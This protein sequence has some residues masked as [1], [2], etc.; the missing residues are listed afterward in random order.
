M[1]N[2]NEEMAMKNA[3]PRIV[4]SP[5]NLP[6]FSVKT[7]AAAHAQG[8]AVAKSGVEPNMIFWPEEKCKETLFL[9]GS[10]E[11]M[12]AI[13]EIGMHGSVLAV[14]NGLEERINLDDVIESILN[15]EAKEV[16]I[17]APGKSMKEDPINRDF[18]DRIHKNISGKL[19]TGMIRMK[20]GKENSMVAEMKYRKDG[21]TVENI[22]K[23]KHAR[24]IRFITIANRVRNVMYFGGIFGMVLQIILDA[25]DSKI[26]PEG[27]Y[28][29]I[30]F[31]WMSSSIIGLI[32]PYILS[33]K[34]PWAFSGPL[35][36]M[37]YKKLAE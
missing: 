17:C 1:N 27:I 5:E 23:E 32:A 29:P 4:V 19:K 11:E 14:T 31:I 3:S 37:I 36:Y 8:I 25:V 12:L 20:N 2:E 30:F 33:I 10:G 28:W 22:E 6:Y 26:I 13:K 15:T 35:P 21:E 16:W 18:Y 9:V 7:I 24:D 34:Y